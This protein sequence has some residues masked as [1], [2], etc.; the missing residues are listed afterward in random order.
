MTRE[1]R[2]KKMKSK[3]Y[4]K[5]EKKETAKS[6]FFFVH[7]TIIGFGVILKIHRAMQCSLLNEMPMKPYKVPNRKTN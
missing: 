3:K 7:H 4:R 1:G 5:I 2:E 6:H